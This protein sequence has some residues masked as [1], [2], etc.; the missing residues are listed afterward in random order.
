[1][2]YHETMA[3]VAPTSELRAELEAM[4]TYESPSVPPMVGILL[5]L[6]FA[7]IGGMYMLLLDAQKAE[8]EMQIN[9]QP[10]VVFVPSWSESTLPA[11]PATSSA[12]EGQ[13]APTPIMS[14]VTAVKPT[15]SEPEQLVP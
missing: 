11:A 8:A 10:E 12:M 7:A 1:M 4:K 14:P 3:N 15:Q 9:K 5:L 13:P 2:S 6:L